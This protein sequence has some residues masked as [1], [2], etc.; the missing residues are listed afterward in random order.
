MKIKKTFE[1][2]VRENPDAFDH[3]DARGENSTYPAGSVASA[4]P[5]HV[6]KALK[7]KSEAQM[8]ISKRTPV[9]R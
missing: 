3:Q 1:D 7:Q 2:L 4:L 8:P 6:K 9:E 5:E